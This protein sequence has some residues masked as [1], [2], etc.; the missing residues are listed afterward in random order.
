MLRRLTIRTAGILVVLLL[1]SHP[2]GAFAQ[3][4]PVTP[5]PQEP[6]ATAEIPARLR[7][8]EGTVTV[9]RAAAG[10]TEAAII[11]LPLGSGDRVWSEPDGRVEIMFED[12]TTLW[13]DGG[14]TLDFVSLPRPG[15][16]PASILRLWTG[17]L[18]AE[19]PF[20]EGI[21]LVPVR[22]DSPSGSVTLPGQGL[23][24][25]DVDD[26]RR[27]WLSAYDGYGL[28]EAGGMTERVTAG[29]RS[30]AELDTAPAIAASF[31][32]LEADNLTTWRDERQTLFASTRQYVG[33]REY[34]PE[35]IAPYAADLEGYGDWAYDDGT[36]AWYWKP[37]AAVAWTPYRDGSWVYTYSGWTWVPATPWAYVTSHYGRWHYANSAAWVWYPGRVWT[38]ASVRWYVG[39]SYVGWTPLNYY[40]SPAVS[41]GTYLGGGV[42][43]GIS[44]GW[45]Y[46]GRGWND[47]GWGYPGYGWGY[48]RYGYGWGWGCC[49]GGY[50]GGDGGWGRGGGWGH[51][52]RYPVHLPARGRNAVYV[53]PYGSAQGGK[54]V[55]GLGYRSGLD[56]AWTVV[57]HDD[58][59]TVNTGRAAVA[60]NAL[61]TDLN[62]S[63][64]AMLSGSLRTRNPAT[65]V[66]SSGYTRS[67]ATATAGRQAVSSG[68]TLDGAVRYATGSRAVNRST[69]TGAGASGAG[70][71]TAPPADGSR[72]QSRGVTPS[73]YASTRS[74]TGQQTTAAG[75]GAVR[76]AQST[77][78]SAPRPSTQS[79]LSGPVRSATRS[80]VPTTRGTTRS[81]GSRQAIRRATSPA[82]TS[83]RSSV[84]GA[85]RQA[86]TRSGATRYPTTSIYS[87][88]GASR[89]ATTTYPRSAPSGAVRAPTGSGVRYPSSGRTATPRFSTP[90]SSPSGS[91]RSIA[92]RGG[93][94]PSIRSAPPRGGSGPSVRSAA[95]RGGAVRSAPRGGAIRSS[96]GPSRPASAPRSGSGVAR[97]RQKDP[98]KP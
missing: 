5:S 21:Q 17:S 59:D 69:A 73:G 42:S 97:R 74:G 13:L 88:S 83:S 41:F 72:L 19:R 16:E 40:G 75:T 9:Q 91:I 67:T 28:L 52:G 76:R 58:L 77:T 44:I 98:N 46:S 95:P 33:E 84:N 64:K 36:A 96:A 48:P 34:V 55:D 43:V 6:T 31:N 60:R 56:N 71:K 32:T 92:P 65:L 24:R 12:G 3:Q 29:N 4:A 2:F 23:F 87:G 7:H 14:T 1:I 50:W 15:R 82:S 89:R 66:P 27:V 86:L 57:P 20:T 68:R 35:T 47:W 81:S 30:F 62:G 18:F 79:G 90:R 78:R 10:E 70:T 93:S 38:P 51:G 49:G 11:N 22:I 63:S 61:P 37:Y 25:V 54:V 45:G 85:V 53:G 94:G 8:F 80:T 26:E 39:S